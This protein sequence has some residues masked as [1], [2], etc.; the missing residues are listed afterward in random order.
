MGI[1]R[2]RS[3]RVVSR[4]LFPRLPEGGDHLSGPM[5]AHWHE[6]ST[7]KSRTGRPYSLAGSAS[8]CDL[9]PG[10]VF[11]AF[12]VAREPG[13]ALTPPFHPY[14]CGRSSFLWH[15]PWGRPLSRFGTALPCGART[16]LPPF[17]GSDHLTRSDYSNPDY[18]IFSSI[19]LF[20]SA[21]ASLFIARGMYCISVLLILASRPF[22]F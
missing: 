20:A 1:M 15:C 2:K 19:A 14:P 18:V 22:T 6:R 8:L 12:P 9:A 13:G 7:R 10:G 17:P 21:S 11:Q 3:E 5:I 4:V 16:F